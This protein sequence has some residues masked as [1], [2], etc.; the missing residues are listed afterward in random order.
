M[1]TFPYFM[2]RL[3]TV[4]FSAV[5]SALLVKAYDFVCKLIKRGV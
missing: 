4:A 5:C 2:M 1:M 3:L